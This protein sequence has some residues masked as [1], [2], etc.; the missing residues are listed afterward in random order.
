MINFGRYHTGHSI[1]KPCICPNTN[2]MCLCEVYMYC[3]VAKTWS[4]NDYTE[5]EVKLPDA[6]VMYLSR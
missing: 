2:S 6:Y 3:L 4:E 5:A 1:V